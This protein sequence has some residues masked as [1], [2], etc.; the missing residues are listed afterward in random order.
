ML[1]F[2]TLFKLFNCNFVFG[3][4]NSFLGCLVPLVFGFQLCVIKACFLFPQSCLLRVVCIL[5][6][7]KY[8][9]SITVESPS[10]VLNLSTWFSPT[11]AQITL[12]EKGLTFVP[13][14]NSWD[15][16]ESQKELHQYH[17]RLKIID[18]FHSKPNR[19][20]TPFTNPV[21]WEQ[22]LSQLDG[23]IQRLIHTERWALAT[24]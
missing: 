21:N 4:C 24:Y 17:R 14:P 1:F 23:K 19:T 10:N 20:P 5:G 18:Y 6:R 15:C 3:P 2:C 9:P 16:G 13:H 7:R 11:P 8:T 12:L 22:Q